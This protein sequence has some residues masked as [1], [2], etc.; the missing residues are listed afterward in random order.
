M[1]LTTYKWTIDR[2]HQAIS[3][4]IFDGQNIE[5][6]RGDLVLIPP[7][8]EAHVYYSDRTANI[9]RQALAGQAQIREDRPITLSNGS[10]PQPDIAIVKPLDTVYLEHHPYPEDI[11]WL[12]EYSHTTLERDLGDKQVIYAQAE[13]P[14]YWVV[15]L[16]DLQL[17]VFRD[18]TPIGYRTKID[19]RSGQIS[20][21]NFPAVSIDVRRLFKV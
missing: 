5:L 11:F 20:P 14:E 12:I 4:G 6:L 16:K 21:I 3:S 13:I 1:T 9:L 7:E 10:E 8:G 19:F 18:S 2:Y 17:T 15:N